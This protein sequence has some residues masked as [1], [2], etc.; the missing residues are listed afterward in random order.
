MAQQ[1]PPTPEKV[2]AD[3]VTRLHVEQA[4]RDRFLGG[5][6]E[7]RDNGRIFG[8]LVLAQAAIAAGYTVDADRTLHSL[9]AYFV[10]GGKPEL[11]I[12]YHVERVRDGRSFTARR[13]LCRQGDEAICDVTASYVRPEEGISHQE[14]LS[15]VPM[16]ED[17]PEF[18]GW[19]ED[20]DPETWPFELRPIMGPDEP[21]EDPNQ[22]AF[23]A[24]WVRIRAPLPADPMF[25]SAAMVF[26]SDAGSFAGIERRYGWDA[27]DFRVSASLDHAI[28]IHRPVV[29]DD[30]IY[31]QTETPVA[32][33]GRA[34]TFRKMYRRDGT[35]I[36]TMAQEAIARRKR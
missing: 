26:D 5:N 35:H 20:D 9:H 16:P 13:V 22:P 10:R 18:T 29:W 24:A 28:W 4:M 17:L 36:S 6:T 1:A 8:G 34:L 27:F 14:P 2:V 15:G 31:T 21:P 3:F 30:W 32:H 7:H 11:P 33:G 25:H 23:A 12:E 19:D